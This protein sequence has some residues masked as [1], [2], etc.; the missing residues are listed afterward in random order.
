MKH[1]DDRVALQAVEFWT[2]VCEEEVEL[3]HEAQEVWT[4]NMQLDTQSQANL[5]SRLPT[6]GN[7]PKLSRNI[8]PRSHCQKLFQCSSHFSPVRKKMRMRMS[9]LY[10]WQ[11]AHVWITSHKQWP[12]ELSQLWS[13]SLKLTLKRRTGIIVKPPLWLSALYSTVLIQQC[14]LHLWTRLY[15]S[16]LIWWQTPMSMWKTPPRGHWAEYVN[17]WLARYNRMC[18]FTLSSQLL[19]MASQTIQELYRTVVGHWW[20]WL[21]NWAAIM[22]KIPMQTQLDHCRLTT[23]VLYRLFFTSRIRES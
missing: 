4:H 17:S 8:L 6:T 12:T 11:P 1:P 3:A 19:S 13:P 7:S 22:K 10:R 15:R 20:I 14:W 23:M 16:W 2:T 5:P 9:G 21:T 18:T